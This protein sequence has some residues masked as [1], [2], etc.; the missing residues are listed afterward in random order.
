MRP[1]SHF[2]LLSIS[3]SE[4]LATL[5]L[6]DLLTY[7]L[8]LHTVCALGRVY[9]VQFDSICVSNNETTSHNTMLQNTL[10]PVTLPSLL[11]AG[12]MLEVGGV[13]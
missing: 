13:S 3:F 9:V 4:L 5:F 11:P 6:R 2:A 1:G 12:S 7:V 8:W 10:P